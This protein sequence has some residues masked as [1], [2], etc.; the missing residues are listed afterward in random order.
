MP[1]RGVGPSPVIP[2]VTAVR[3]GEFQGLGSEGSSVRTTRCPQPL[4]SFPVE[5]PEFHSQRGFPVLL[6]LYPKP[7]VPREAWRA[8][9]PC[10]IPGRSGPALPQLVVCRPRVPSQRRFLP[11]GRPRGRVSIPASG[12]PK[13]TVHPPWSPAAKACLLREKNSFRFRVAALGVAL[14]KARSNV[15]EDV[16]VSSHTVSVMFECIAD[17]R[18]QDLVRAAFGICGRLFQHFNQMTGRDGVFLISVDA[19]P[20]ERTRPRRLPCHCSYLLGKVKDPGPPAV[21]QGGQSVNV[22]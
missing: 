6:P 15:R 11:E 18:C 14:P 16:A 7:S 5:R 10:P 12:V 9:P 22:R 1:R 19:D 3:P 20:S 2:I 8:E 13:T 21:Y 17:P 4:D